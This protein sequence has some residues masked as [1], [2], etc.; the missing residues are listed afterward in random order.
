M[1]K[2]IV[3]FYCKIAITLYILMI[4]FLLL[5]YR[6]NFDKETV[7]SKFPYSYKSFLGLAAYLDCSY[8]VMTL[9]DR[10]LYA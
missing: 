5:P 7:N 4:E 6:S 10:W 3:H 8:Y 2:K 9:L 1:Y